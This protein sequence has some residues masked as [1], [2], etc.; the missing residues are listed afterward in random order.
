[1]SK[2]EDETFADWHPRDVRRLIRA[3]ELRDRPTSGMC[4][5]YAQANVTILPK[6]LADDFETFCS[7]NTGAFPMMYR[8]KPGELTAPP[9]A[10]ESDIRTDG[11][12]SVCKNGRIL[13]EAG[14]LLQYTEEMKDMVT[15][16]TGCSFSFEGAFLEAGVPLRNVEQK[17]DVGIFRT[18]I[19][20]QP[21]NSFDCEV[22]VSMRY[23]PAD[24]LETAFRVTHWTPT[25]HGAPIHIGD[26][27]VIGISDLENIDWGDVVKPSP[28]DVPAFW[29]CGVTM[30]PAVMSASP[31]I[32][33]FTR[34]TKGCLFLCDTKT[35]FVK[36]TNMADTPSVVQIS[37][38]PLLY[39]VASENAVGIVHELERL[40]LPVREAQNG[41][42]SDVHEEGTL[43]KSA[44]SLSH[45]SSIA[46]VAITC[47]DKEPSS[48]KQYEGLQSAVAITGMLQ[49]LGKDVTVVTDET[50]TKHVENI[51]RELVHVGYLKKAFTVLPYPQNNIASADRNMPLQFLTEENDPRKPK[52]DH[53]VRIG[54][55]VQPEKSSNDTQGI[56]QLF[57]V[58][59][60]WIKSTGIGADRSDTEIS[61][62]YTIETGVYSSWALTLALLVLNACPI[63]DRYR[64]RS[65]GAAKDMKDA[66]EAAI[67][68]EREQLALSVVLK[69]TNNRE[70]LEELQFSAEQKGVITAM[71]N[72]A[73]LV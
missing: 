58:K 45:A 60:P 61:T 14:T 5:G 32:G 17:L 25:S 7:L 8:S 21:F 29:P 43:L 39:S 4:S 49:A 65:V 44:L 62:D 2:W 50:S 16:Y 10:E 73:V 13:P 59:L 18:S 53:L 6:S 26:P 37:Q 69:Q 68:I 9:L 12:Y 67:S 35:T 72:L 42:L 36:G 22:V 19:R 51:A 30:E 24:K 71:R 20:C 40:I 56:D 54:S 33:F 48:Q 23:I 3:G 1:M 46:V 41:C 34:G 70:I 38:N 55:S 63:H 27:A 66:T 64:R 28:G 47:P 11:V 31:S 57:L 52:F 15:F